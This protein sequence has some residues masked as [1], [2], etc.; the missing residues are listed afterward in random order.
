MRRRAFLQLPL[1]GTALAAAGSDLPAYRIVSRY[2]PAK[3]PGMPGPFPGRV[4]SVHSARSIDEQT[5]QADPDVVREM[6]ARGMTTLT[7]EPTPAAAW[8]RFFDPADVVGIKVNCSGAPHVCSNPVVVAEITRNLTAAGVKPSNIYIYER[9]D[10]QLVSVGY[11]K[12]VPEGV[13]VLAIEVP[14]LSIRGYDPATYVE[15]DFFGED[16]TRSNLVRL[17]S[18]TFTKIINVPNMKDHGAAG[19]T[20]CLKNIAYGNFSNVARSHQ[21]E[22]T[23][24]LSFIGTLASVEPLHSKT[25]LQV[26]DGLKGV[27][28]GGPFV[29]DPRFAF[30]PKQ[31]VVGTD[32]VAIDR[33]LLDIIEDKR[34]AEHAPSVWDRSMEHV[35]PDHPLDPNFNAFIRE[36]GHIEFAGHLG[37]GVYDQ[38][39]IRHSKIEV[40]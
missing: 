7:G 23:N 4:V 35:G 19:V 18:S 29:R 33:Q 22:K 28:H 16:D 8:R 3:N 27:W 39:K 10:G 5:G 21:N 12:Y 36:P 34:R 31:I 17:V 13:H 6:L 1:A 26:M 30:Y 24:T 11:P 2:K 38:S 25:V 14:R 32:P 20:G 37:L 40:A 15:V 9:F